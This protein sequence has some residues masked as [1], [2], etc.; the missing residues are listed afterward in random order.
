MGV[1]VGVTVGS[2]ATTAA[3][4]VAPKSEAGVGGVELPLEHATASSNS[5]SHGSN[6]FPT[7]KLQLAP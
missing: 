2:A 1:G 5:G 3:S 6:T 7:L 4:T